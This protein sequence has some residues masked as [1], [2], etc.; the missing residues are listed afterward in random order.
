MKLFHL[1]FLPLL[2]S[3]APLSDDYVCVSPGT[4]SP[5]SA[6]DYPYVGGRTELIP[7]SQWVE[8]GGF[9]GALSIQSIAMTYGAYISQDIV[10]S[11]EEEGQ[12]TRGRVRTTTNIRKHTLA[13]F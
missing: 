8:S 3:A 12:E 6:D 1:L 7:R 9:C 11:K 2:T 10:V 5:P 13:H 4:C